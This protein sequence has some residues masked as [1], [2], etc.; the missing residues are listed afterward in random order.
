MKGGKEV[1]FQS[2]YGVDQITDP[3]R[4]VDDVR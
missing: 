3:T 2:I 1:V 4:L